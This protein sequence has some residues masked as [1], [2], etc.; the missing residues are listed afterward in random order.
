MIRIYLRV[1]SLDDGGSAAFE[2]REFGDG[3]EELADEV[4]CDGRYHQL[5]MCAK[6][7]AARF[8]CA[9]PNPPCYS[10]EALAAFSACRSFGWRQDNE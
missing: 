7:T 10:S 4:C 1:V 8:F 2:M 9:K 6:D 5:M 3:Q